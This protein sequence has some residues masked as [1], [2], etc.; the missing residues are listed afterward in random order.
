[1][2]KKRTPTAMFGARL[3]RARL[4]KGLTQLQVAEHLMIDRTTYAKYEAGA[5]QPPL[6]G[7]YR[8]TRLLEVTADELIRPD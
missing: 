5:V 2:K 4:Q 6:E 1:M 8:L 7:L 3:R